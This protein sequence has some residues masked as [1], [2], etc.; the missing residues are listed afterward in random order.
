MRITKVLLV[1][2]IAVGLVGCGST[3]FRPSASGPSSSSPTNRAKP[4]PS[5][6]ASPKTKREGLASR[7]EPKTEA[8]AREAAVQFYGLYSAKQF[9]AS[10]DLLTPSV[11][12]QIPLSVWVGVHA[13]CPS[14][15]AG[16]TRVIKAVTVFG[17][18]AIITEEI[19]GT[20]S[21]LG[22][23]EDVFNYGHHHWRYTPGELGIYHH[24]SVAADV[25]AAKAADLCSSKK[26]SLL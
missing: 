6:T 14:I 5:A 13:G 17:N 26:A 4:S 10:W 2:L 16:K 23:T 8:G 7:P 11:K 3:V 1:G 25:A 18:A 22:T 15:G 20:L 24:G 9:T 12:R 19:G 21:S